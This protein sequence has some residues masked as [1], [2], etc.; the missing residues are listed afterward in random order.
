MG[1]QDGG[2]G[3]STRTGVTLARSR[4]APNWETLCQ[5][6]PWGQGKDAPSSPAEP[7]MSSV[8]QAVSPAA[9][10]AP[11]PAVKP[12]SDPPQV[13]HHSLFEAFD[14][15]TQLEGAA[16]AL[17]ATTL[18]PTARPTAFKPAETP[19]AGGEAS[20][21][22]WV[23]AEGGLSAIG[24]SDL[25]PRRYE[26][27]VEAVS[28]LESTPLPEPV[29]Q[30]PAPSS[31]VA[32]FAPV[33]VSVSIEPAPVE[34][35][36]EPAPVEISAASEP[37]PVEI[38]HPAPVAEAAVEVPAPKLEPVAHPVP[39][40]EA[41]VEAPVRRLEPVRVPLTPVPPKQA[42]RNAMDAATME[43][44]A[45]EMA[46]MTTRPAPLGVSASSKAPPAAKPKPKPKAQVR[47]ST[48]GPALATSLFSA[49]KRAAERA[50][51]GVGLAAGKQPKRSAPPPPPAK[52][53]T[54]KAQSAG[55]A[56]AVKVPA[57][58]KPAVPRV[59]GVVER[60]VG[61]ALGAL[62]SVGSGLIRQAQSVIVPKP[63]SKP[64]PTQRP[65]SAARGK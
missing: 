30:P 12:E 14:A 31:P 51:K 48:A 53:T 50:I 42:S 45:A 44:L 47:P 28:T 36:A 56:P 41:F 63:R 17:A 35:A 16:P 27:S 26:A 18:P 46:P 6:A 2:E 55:R 49:V 25:A 11:T 33:L 65:V 64:K 61:I 58:A 29:V 15:W 34:A 39:I 23:E 1:S 5:A 19:M 54:V 37:A 7:A 4:G 22:A 52:P 38:A 21:L 60:E 62:K 57:R 10:V 24:S 40:V 59:L 3:V 43:A 8:T 13:V 32:E 20:F 9:V